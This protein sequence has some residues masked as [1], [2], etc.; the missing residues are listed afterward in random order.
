M[1]PSQL[2]RW[3]ALVQR[4]TV[5]PFLSKSKLLGG[6]QQAES[7]RVKTRK[8]GP[9]LCFARTS[10]GPRAWPIC[11]CDICVAEPTWYLNA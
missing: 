3:S 11:S 2:R 5:G 9:P 8:P 10:L 1:Q 6:H 7:L 4:R